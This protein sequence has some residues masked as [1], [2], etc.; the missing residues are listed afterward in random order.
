MPVEPAV[1]PFHIL[2]ETNALRQVVVHTP[3]EEMALVSPE[4]ADEL[5]FD[6]ILFLEEAREE[7]AML[8]RLFQAAVGREDAVLQVTDLLRETFEA[9]EARTAFGRRRRPCRRTTRCHTAP[10]NQQT[11]SSTRL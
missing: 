8:I 1:A 5:L 2:S 10:P 9:A 6:D 11:T 3:G 7:H 4:N